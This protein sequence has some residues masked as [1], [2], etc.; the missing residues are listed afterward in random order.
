MFT[1]DPYIT[2]ADYANLEQ[3][4]DSYGAD[5]IDPR[6][7]A[8]GVLFVDFVTRD[9][10]E[11][12]PKIQI[13]PTSDGGIAFG[14]AGVKQAPNIRSLE[15]ELEIDPT[16]S[17]SYWYGGEWNEEKLEYETKFE[18][19]EHETYGVN[20]GPRKVVHFLV[21]REGPLTFSIDVSMCLPFVPPVHIDTPIT[22][23][24]KY[25][26]SIHQFKYY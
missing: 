10:P 11:L 9:A 5:P 15:V 6:A 18:T 13:F 1:E 3:D 24:E 20:Y 14:W 23:G 19:D 22:L 12:L 25:G 17:Y 26:D 7:I 4:W 16:G 2:L 21:H 8:C